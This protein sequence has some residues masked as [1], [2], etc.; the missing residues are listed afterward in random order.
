MRATGRR[1]TKPEKALR[2]ELHRRGL[3]FWVDREVLR[4]SRR[5]A[6]IIFPRARVAIFVD[7][8]FWHGCPLHASWPR[9]NAAWWRE[10]IEANHRRD[11]DTNLRLAAVG[12]RSVRVWE[13]EPVEAA[14]GRVEAVVESRRSTVT[15]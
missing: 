14:A 1:D 6:D 2:S 10:K 15:Q 8:C 3:R 9:S 11:K 13:H 4:G 12:W 7:G 5:R